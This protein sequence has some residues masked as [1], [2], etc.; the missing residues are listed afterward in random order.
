[1]SRPRRAAAKHFSGNPIA[2]FVPLETKEANLAN[3]QFAKSTIGAFVDEQIGDA[4]NNVMYK[5][6]SVAKAFGAAQNLVVQQE[7]SQPGGVLATGV[8]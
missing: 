1:M 3:G 2:S 4:W 8:G 5:H 6:E 7:H